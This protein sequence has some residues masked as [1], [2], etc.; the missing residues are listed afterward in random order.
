MAIAD[1]SGHWII[2]GAYANLDFKN[3]GDILLRFFLPPF[4]CMSVVCMRAHKGVCACVQGH[5]G[6]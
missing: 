2:H 5:G 4:T 3:K 1:G 6:C